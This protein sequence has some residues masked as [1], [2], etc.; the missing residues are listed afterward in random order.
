MPP[1]TR[2]FR[3]RARRIGRRGRRH[4]HPRRTRPLPATAC[5][6]RARRLRR[7]SRRRPYPAPWTPPRTTASPHPRRGS[8]F[9]PRTTMRPSAAERRPVARTLRRGFRPRRRRRAGPIPRTRPR[10]TRGRIPR[11]T[12]PARRRRR[13]PAPARARRNGA[14]REARRRRRGKGTAS[15]R[16]GARRGSRRF[17]SIDKVGVG[18][19]GAYTTWSAV[20]TCDVDAHTSATRVSAPNIVR[21]R[22]PVCEASNPRRCQTIKHREPTSVGKT[23][24]SQVSR[25][26]SPRRLSLLYVRY[27]RVI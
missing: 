8:S 26:Q 14:A 15:G 11:E 7:R 12:S 6:L 17:G 18:G 20:A 5:R 13:R 10:G 27:L 3:R 19:G 24:L 21:F 22:A 25:R 1:P 9:P 4:R 2:W 23:S 16:A